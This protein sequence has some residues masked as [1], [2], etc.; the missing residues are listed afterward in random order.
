ME[1]YNWIDISI[2][3]GANFPPV[4][5]WTIFDSP[6][7]FLERPQARRDQI[8][9]L[10]RASTQAVYDAFNCY[11]ILCGDD[12]WGNTPFSAGCFKS[13]EKYSIQKESDLKNWLH[14]RGIPFL[15][16]VLLL[17]VFSADGDPAVLTMWEILVE[18]AAEIF[19]GENLV[20]IGENADWCLYYHDDGAI[21]FAREPNTEN[22]V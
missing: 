19:A 5:R 3:Q 8:L 20:V 21:T 9:F 14:Q 12:G 4:N 22:A 10:D 2:L 7:A 11:D 16:K 6:E 1:P 18:F 13:V 15:A 17:P